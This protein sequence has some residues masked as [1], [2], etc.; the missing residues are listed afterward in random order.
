M[1]A[2]PTPIAVR[3]AILFS[4]SSEYQNAGH[5][6]HD[7]D[8]FPHAR[9]QNRFAV[10]GPDVDVLL[11]ARPSFTVAMEG[12]PVVFRLIRLP[13]GSAWLLS[14]TT[15]AEYGAPFICLL[16]RHARV[17]LRPPDWLVDFILREDGRAQ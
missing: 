9:R 14:M 6:I 8:V 12:D 7:R 3:Q 2:P 1:I 16:E 13:S 11:A 5:R 15:S 4:G 17:P 10:R